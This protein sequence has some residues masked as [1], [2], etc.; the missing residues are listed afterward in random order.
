MCVP[1]LTTKLSHFKCC[2]FK[3]S[4]YSKNRDLAVVLELMSGI[5]SFDHFSRPAVQQQGPVWP[6]CHWLRLN[7]V[8][9]AGCWGKRSSQMHSGSMFSGCDLVTLMHAIVETI[10]KTEGFTLFGG[11]WVRE[12]CVLWVKFCWFSSEYIWVLKSVFL[13][14]RYCVCSLMQD[15]EEHI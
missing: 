13:W 9:E 12:L 15:I 2:Y 10:W 11:W 5:T 14:R 6:C 7:G 3:G 8:S 1:N 4:G